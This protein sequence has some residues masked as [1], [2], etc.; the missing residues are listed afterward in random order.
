MNG[1]EHKMEQ[2]QYHDGDG[3]NKITER[4]PFPNGVIAM[5]EIRRGHD[6]VENQKER[7]AVLR[8]DDVG[9]DALC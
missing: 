9:R 2:K 5:N 3:P 7:N 1:A 6:Q 4:V 8:H